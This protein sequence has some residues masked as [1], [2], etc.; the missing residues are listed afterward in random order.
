MYPKSTMG[1]ALVVNVHSCGTVTTIPFYNTSITQKT[2][3]YSFT[4]Q[5]ISDTLQA[6]QTVL[7]V[8]PLYK[9]LSDLFL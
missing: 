7:Y 3:H 6:R 4:Q 2:L 5:V 1:T 9:G 8:L